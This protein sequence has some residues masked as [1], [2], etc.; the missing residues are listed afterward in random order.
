MQ[1]KRKLEKLLKKK[2]DTDLIAEPSLKFPDLD[3]FLVLHGSRT[4]I[5][6][7]VIAGFK[8]VFVV[9]V[10]VAA[11]PRAARRR[12]GVAAT[13]RLVPHRAAAQARASLRRRL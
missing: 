8:V 10:A 9:A 3:S 4:T 12:G 2:M 5:A 6:T 7:I 11:L 13:A 1:K